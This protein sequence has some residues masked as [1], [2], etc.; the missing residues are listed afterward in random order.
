M[1]DLFK[2]KS[3]SHNLG[4]ES[5]LEQSKQS[6]PEDQSLMEMFAE[7]QQP[8][9]TISP[10]HDTVTNV[11]DGLSYEASTVESLNDSGDMYVI[12]I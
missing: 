8:F 2:S 4:I 6:V 1:I 3:S 5:T 11:M 12:F 7:P 9:E 10:S